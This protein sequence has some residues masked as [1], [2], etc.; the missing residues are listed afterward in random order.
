LGPEK[1]AKLNDTHVVFCHF[2]KVRR[3][4]YEINFEL[5]T[6]DP[7]SFKDGELTKLFAAKVEQAVKLKPANYLWSHRRWKWSF[8]QS[9]HGSLEI[10]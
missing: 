4:Y 6:S 7:S 9:K 10:K 2:Y 5:I 3:G 8:D 1:G